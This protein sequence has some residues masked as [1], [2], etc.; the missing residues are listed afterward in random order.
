[1]MIELNKPAVLTSQNFGLNSLLLDEQELFLPCKKAEIEIK[2]VSK[3]GI[4]EKA[5]FLLTRNLFELKSTLEKTIKIT[6]NTFKPIEISV[7]STKR[8]CTKLKIE[9]EENVKAQVVVNL[10]GNEWQKNELMLVALKN[11]NLDVIVFCDGGGK[12]FCGIETIQK[13]KAELKLTV[14]DF[15][16]SV[17]L[18]NIFSKNEEKNSKLNL[19]ILYA[20]TD[21]QKIDINVLAEN[22]SPKA[23]TNI[24]VL[25]GLCGL[26]EKSF[27]GVIDFKRGAKKSVGVE[28]EYAVLLNSGTKSK[29]LPV[30]LCGEEDVV[31]SHGASSGKLSEE[32]LFYVMSRGV[33]LNEAKKL[34]VKAKFNKILKQLFDEKTKQKTS[35]K[36][37]RSIDGK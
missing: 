12:N 30:L 7:V 1:M 28:N 10:C 4:S 29:S 21:A 37:D 18:Q 32:E 22:S 15:C 5:N 24:C 16:E 26:A 31:G 2:N 27:K 3:S 23:Q 34:L 11:S 8:S 14:L 33:N 19:N 20:K 9:C 35:Q 6:K 36:I 25:G 13:E 17:S